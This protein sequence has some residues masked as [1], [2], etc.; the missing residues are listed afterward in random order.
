MTYSNQVAETVRK[1][2]SPGLREVN[3]RKISQNG[4]GDPLNSYPHSMIWFRDKLY[5]ATTRANLHLLWFTIGERIHNF[6]AWPV[7]PPENPHDLDL[8]AQIW[9]YDPGPDSWENVYVSPM[10]MGSEGFEVP[11][12][13]GFRGMAI[14]QAPDD[15]EPAIYVPTWSP[16]LGPGPVLLRSRDGKQF[17]RVSKPGLGDSTVTTIRSVVSYKGKLFVA[18]TGTT[19][20][21]FSANVPDRLVVMVGHSLVDSDWQLACEPYFGDRT[22]EGVFCMTVYN[23]YLY[24]G[25]YNS[26]E[27]FQ[28]WKTEAEG[29]PPYTWS[30][31]LAHGCY[32]GKENQATVSMAVFKGSLYI[33]G[34]ILG[35]YDKP[36]NIGP[37]SPELIRVHA[38]DSWDL[39]VGDARITPDGLKVPASGLA[40]GFSSPTAG[41]FWQM[42]VHE[43]WLYMG[44]YD[45]LNWLRYVNTDNMSIRV[46][47]CLKG[48]GIDKLVDC[49]AGFDLWRS[50]DGD[51]WLP[52]T[53]NGF[54]NHYNFGIR[55]M[56][57]TKH[58]LFIGA[59]NPFGTKTGIKRAGGWRYETNPHGSLEIWLGKAG[60]IGG[61][62]VGGSPPAPSAVKLQVA[63]RLPGRKLEE[64]ELGAF[65]DAIIDEFYDMSG[66]RHCGCWNQRTD[67]PR[68]AC[69]NL[70][71]EILFFIDEDSSRILELGS[72]RGATTEAIAAHCP[73]AVITAFGVSK[74][75]KALVRKRVPHVKWRLLKNRLRK[76]RS[77]SIDAVIS[78]EAKVL[79]AQL[80]TDIHRILKDG[81]TLVFTDTLGDTGSFA[82]PLENCIASS[83]NE[84]EQVLH[85][86]GFSEVQVHDMTE[87]CL[88]KYR[89]Y[90]HQDFQL[91]FLEKNIDATIFDEV[92]RQLP[93][94]H[95]AAT[96]YVLGVVTKTKITGKTE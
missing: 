78:V 26:E 38:D 16:R 30:K 80:F 69:L 95:S 15:S 68:A 48:I 92:V 72:G 44:T 88:R 54:G 59:A 63:S 81:G 60:T 56:A 25:T 79:N 82:D 23:G 41:Y 50:A 83:V 12:A 66:F 75:E 93:Q 65:C 9:C 17:E 76:I 21:R 10:I 67:S 29:S 2:V 19:K 6:Q 77:N 36:R 74:S 22:N 47:N 4:F 89:E 51:S 28:L 18:P 3:F 31:I 34:G 84:Y 42:C 85:H 1:D 5:V 86:V 62:H 71:E 73:G 14:H 43:G 55:T 46:R 57:S 91:H 64:E 52:V 37:A 32:R 35:G 11:L 20:N 33:G 96:G 27:G 40:S 13:I 61:R 49:L 24:A 94:A 90:V 70:M 87:S 58:G 39:I 53:K 8:R 7:Q 45:I